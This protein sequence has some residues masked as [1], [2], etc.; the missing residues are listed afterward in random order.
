MAIIDIVDKELMRRIEVVTEINKAKYKLLEIAI[1]GL[2]AIK[3]QG[4]PIAQRTLDEM[5][6]SIPENLEIDV[7]NQIEKSLHPDDEK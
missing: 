5:A 7:Y 6:A 3:E 1:S 4:N 2:M